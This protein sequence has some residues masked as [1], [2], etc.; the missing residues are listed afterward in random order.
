MAHHKRGRARRRRAGCKLCK[1]W[2]LNGH[3]TER[4]GGERFGDH[5]RRLAAGREIHEITR[6]AG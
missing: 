6:D 3:R 2:K 1:P 4:A 5:R